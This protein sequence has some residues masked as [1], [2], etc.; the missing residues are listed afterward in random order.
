MQMFPIYGTKGH[1]NG[2]EEY[3]S[4]M[5]HFLV[6]SQRNRTPTEYLDQH[7]RQSSPPFSLKHQVQYMPR[8]IEAVLYVGIFFNLSRIC[9]YCLRQ[10]KCSITNL[11]GRMSSTAGPFC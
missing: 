9:I 3:E 11:A 7:V 8:C 6:R 1:F 4:D 2:F 5:N 10:N